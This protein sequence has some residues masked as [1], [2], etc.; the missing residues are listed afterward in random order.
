MAAFPAGRPSA[1]LLALGL[2]LSCVV[3]DAPAQTIPLEPGALPPADVIALAPGGFEKAL[4]DLP[5]FVTAILRQSGVPGAAVAVVRGGQTVFAD[6]FGLRR[7]GTREAVD[8]R[9]VFQIASLSKPIAGTVA[10]IQVSAGVVKWDDPV[11][12]HLPAFRLK[13]DYVTAKATIG[14]FFAHRSGLPP[15]AG[16][17]LED[18]G[19]D[20]PEIIARLRHVAL[21]PFRISY[22]YANFGTTI[23]AEA[24]AAA[25][26]RSWEDL[27][28]DVLF[29]PL[30]MTDT[31]YRH[32]DF[33][34]R[35]NRAALHVWLNGTFQPLYERN[36]DA[37]APAGGVSSSVVDLAEWL[38]LLLADGRR[39]GRDLISPEALMPALRAQ[40]V[41]GPARTPDSRTSFYGYGFNVSVNANGRPSMG[42]SGAFILG[43]GTSMQ[44]IPSADVAIVVLTNGG[45][46]GVAEAISA[47]FLDITQYGAPT[48]DWYP[49]FHALMLP[50]HD[51]V[52]DL[53]GKPRP[54]DPP[55]ARPLEAYVG[56]YDNAYFGP[57]R[58]ERAGD[59]LVFSVGPGGF[60]LP[61]T[62][63]SGD[64]FAIAPGTEN[65]PAGSL[66]SLSFEMGGSRA[67]AFSVDYL[68]TEGLARWER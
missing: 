4:A 68:D 55:P 50:Y 42:H 66:S 26:G 52:G 34:A 63:W 47:R 11:V 46:V 44:M 2:A 67:A 43:A 32:A 64:T 18:I 38:K 13:D 23:A 62:H 56:S 29:T 65:A 12:S 14:D 5:S 24:V 59:G 20:R 9:T 35:P 53:A 15:S 61:M 27:A 1:A 25:S 6:G 10:A 36:P 37:Q 21:D 49:L 60:R 33:L 45:P 58:I 41:S 22:N 28:R 40:V 51:P 7:A 57:A 39:E 17:D 16:D 54:A 30:G 8:A 3:T 31:S 19:F 48:R